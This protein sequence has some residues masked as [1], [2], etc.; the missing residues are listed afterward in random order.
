MQPVHADALARGAGD[1]LAVADVDRSVGAA[2]GDDDV[3]GGRAGDLRQSHLAVGVTR[4]TD[5]GLSV[6]VL[7][8]GG[9]VHLGPRDAD[10][11]IGCSDNAGV[12]AAAG[13]LRL[14]LW[15]WFRLRL[16]G[17][18]GALVLRSGL[19]LCFRLALLFGLSL[20]LALLLGLCGL[21]LLL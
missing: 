20:R 11:A 16:T 3:T 21:S 9:A 1:D 18:G 12:A 4:H 10:V 2:V 8:H 7:H 15:L 13:G 5:A 17:S 6:G 19:G 14:R